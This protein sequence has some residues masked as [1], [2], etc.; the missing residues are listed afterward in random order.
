MFSNNFEEE[1]YLTRL[2]ILEGF[3]FYPFISNSFKF[4]RYLGVLDGEISL[5]C[6]K[7]R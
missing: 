1:D 7:L 2:E 6:K 3:N 4:Y 5:P